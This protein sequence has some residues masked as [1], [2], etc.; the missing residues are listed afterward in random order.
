[1]NGTLLGDAHLVELA[2]HGVRS[3]GKLR[4]IAFSQGY[5]VL[6]GG[7][8]SGKTTVYEVIQSLLSE[9]PSLR[10][11]SKFSTEAELRRDFCRAGFILAAG[12]TRYRLIQ[13]FKDKS[14][15]VSK[16]DSRKNKFLRIKLSSV[17]TMKLL[18][19]EMGLPV[20]HVLGE[21]CSLKR[22]DLPSRREGAP[23][24]CRTAI[25][26]FIRIKGL[27]PKLVFSSLKPGLSR[28][29]QAF[30][31]G[32]WTEVEFGESGEVL[33]RGP[34]QSL[35]V[36]VESLGLETQVRVYAAIRYTLFQVEGRGGGGL[37]LLDDPFD[38]GDGQAALFG[39]ALTALGKTSQ[40]IHLTS[41]PVYTRWANQVIKL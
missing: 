19:Q 30:T 29:V 15:R 17:E 13:D 10:A 1:M 3:F 38:F 14:S 2:L 33:L 16:F 8:S 27:L 36:A 9:N 32:E 35:N 37:F 34:A 18:G 22:S 20:G 7:A 11:S 41:N 6:L 31:A 40:V 21:I 24:A 39:R 26:E 12:H 28:N 4:R 23:E 25:H 5:N